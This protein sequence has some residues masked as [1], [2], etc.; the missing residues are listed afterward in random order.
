MEVAYT[1]HLSKFLLSTKVQAEFGLGML[2]D[3]TVLF[4]HTLLVNLLGHSILKILGFLSYKIG[5]IP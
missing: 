1:G 4:H 2:G 3:K 5:L